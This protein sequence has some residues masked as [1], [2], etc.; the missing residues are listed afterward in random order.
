MLPFRT[1]LHFYKTGR[2]EFL[3]QRIPHIKVNVKIFPYN[4]SLQKLSPYFFLVCAE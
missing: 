2:D 4:F 3:H 1:N